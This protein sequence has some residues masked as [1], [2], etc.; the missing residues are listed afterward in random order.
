MT[1]TII[2]LLIGGAIGAAFGA[3]AM[4]LVAAT[5]QPC[6]QCGEDVPT[7]N[8]GGVIGPPPG[9]QRMPGERVV[10]LAEMRFKLDNAGVPQ[11]IAEQ[12]LNREALGQ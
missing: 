8:E 2:P 10:P 5:A 12:V 1:S 6:R 11:A 4:A 3:F 9:V 7:F